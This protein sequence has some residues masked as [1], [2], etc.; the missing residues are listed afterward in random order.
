MCPYIL[1]HFYLYCQHDRMRYKFLIVALLCFVASCKSDGNK[2]K[3]ALS[4]REATDSL[5][6]QEDSL[7]QNVM[8]IHDS[9]MML[10]SNVSSLNRKIKAVSDK[11]TDVEVREEISKVSQGLEAANEEMMNWM[12][13]FDPDLDSIS[14]EETMKYLEREKKKIEGV[15]NNMESAIENAEVLLQ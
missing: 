10:M 14:H 5:S 4:D 11:T 2:E 7:Y 1:N 15:K 3:E 12:R 13:N 6:S 8:V 9:A